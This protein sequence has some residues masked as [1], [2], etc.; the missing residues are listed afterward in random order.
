MEYFSIGQIVKSNSGRDKN[1]LFIVTRLSENGYV[2]VVDGE[3]RTVQ[4][5]KRKNT[6]HLYD[7]KHVASI[8]IDEKTKDPN[9]L[10]ATI[11]KELK[12]LGNEMEENS[13][14]LKKT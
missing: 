12:R 13:L 3:S 14:C 1:K 2:Y 6:K 5:P 10:N 11:R 7:M 8:Q 9:S 4:K